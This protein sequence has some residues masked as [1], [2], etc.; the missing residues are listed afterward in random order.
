MWHWHYWTITPLCGGWRYCQHGL[1]FL[2]FLFFSFWT[3]SLWTDCLEHFVFL[4]SG[5]WN[6]VFLFSNLSLVFL[7]PF[8]YFF[9]ESE[10][11]AGSRK[12]PQCSDTLNTAS[13]PTTGRSSCCNGPR[14]WCVVS[15]CRES[16]GGCMRRWCC[17]CCWRC[18]C[19]A[20][21]GW[22]QPSSMTTSPGRASMV[23]FNAAS[24]PGRDVNNESI[25]DYC[26][27]RVQSVKLNYFSY[28]NNF[29]Q[30][31]NIIITVQWQERSSH[32]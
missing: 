29:T 3:F 22:R 25:I 15:C 21:C 19:W 28:L 12:V 31:V 30:V 13:W 8:A 23:G 16:W 11:F 2:F 20:S 9:T 32:L 6:L 4:W 7:M 5:L 27:L 26:W 10:G 18:S 17:C 1:F 14:C 24:F